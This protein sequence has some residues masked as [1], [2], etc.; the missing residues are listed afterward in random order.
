[1]ACYLLTVGH[2]PGGDPPLGEIQVMNSTDLFLQEGVWSVFVW[3]VDR[4]G[5]ISAA[6]LMIGPFMVDTIAPSAVQ[7]TVE[8]TLGMDGWYRSEVSISMDAEDER[9]GVSHYEMSMDGMEWVQQSSPLLLSAEGRH[10]RWVRAV[11]GAGNRGPVSG[12]QVGV[13]LTAPVTVAVT[14]I[15]PAGGWFDSP[16]T[17]HLESGDAWSGVVLR[18]RLNEDD[19]QQGTD[20]FLLGDGIHTLAFYAVDGAGNEEEPSLLT[21]SVDAS[22]PRL[23]ELTGD[24]L[25]CLDSDPRPL[26]LTANA[27]DAWSGLGHLSFAFRFGDGEWS[28]DLTAEPGEGGSYSILI[29]AETWMANVGTQLTWTVKASDILGHSDEASATLVIADDDVLPPEGPEITLGPD[30][31]LLLHSNDQSGWAITVGYF[32]STSPD[33]VFEVAPIPDA[34][35]HALFALGA[36]TLIAHLGEEIFFRYQVRDLDAD[37]PGDSSCGPL[38]AWSSL[39]TIEDTTPPVSLVAVDGTTTGVWFTTMPVLNITASD[40]MSGLR[41]IWIKVDDAE[42]ALYSLPPQLEDGVHCILISAE[43]VAGNREEP[44]QLDL[45][46]D[47]TSPLVE[48]SIMGA[49]AIGGWRNSSA[50]FTMSAT[51]PSSGVSSVEFCLDGS[52]WRPYSTPVPLV[53]GHH[54]IQCRAEDNAGNVRYAS[55]LQVAIDSIAPLLNLSALFAGNTAVDVVASDEL[56]GIS[57]L[58]LSIDGGP[59]SILPSNSSWHGSFDLSSG[60]HVITLTARDAAGNQATRSVQVNV[61]AS[62]VSPW[63]VIIMLGAVGLIAV[64]AL[65]LVRRRR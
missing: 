38:S 53:D 63:P 31:S 44:Q 23:D 57:A 29:P 40:A 25:D 2:D 58:T 27:F 49:S 12:A 39:G 56:S 36:D 19:W 4:S 32:F 26:R 41:G 7:L 30:Y 37:R 55:P 17:V 15:S 48:G 9:S 14:D 65:I 51:D 1:V 5:W 33:N 62:P 59:P 20:T 6:P 54:D 61:P 60:D 50:I 22:A 11:D 42:W 16:V 13:D 46:I 24:P 64:G 43:D 52:P 18:S 28:E 21:F 34:E 35:G 8:G 10:E 45:E 47:V 3:S